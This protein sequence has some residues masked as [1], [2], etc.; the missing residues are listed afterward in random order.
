MEAIARLKAECRRLEAEIH[1]LERKTHDSKHG[2][3]VE[4]SPKVT[5]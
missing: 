3:R 1:V 4:P 2:V 5:R